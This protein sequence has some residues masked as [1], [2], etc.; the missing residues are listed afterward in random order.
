MTQA[1]VDDLQRQLAKLKAQHPQ[2]AKEMQRLAELGDFSENAAYQ[3][4]KSRLRGINERMRQLDER[5]KHA[6]IIAPQNDGTIGLGSTVSVELNGV[7]QTF[8]IL[9][10]S[11]TSPGQGV[12]SHHSPIGT[13]LVGRKA[14]DELTIK[15]TDREISCRIIAVK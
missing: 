11:E 7:K 2:A 4:A 14:G 5:L 10:S 15:L 9:G 3:M 8:L 6:V 1:K 13:A 12:I